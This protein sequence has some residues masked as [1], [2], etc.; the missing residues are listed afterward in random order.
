MILD[1][2]A[3]QRFRT[4][5]REHFGAVADDPLYEAVSAGRKLQGCEHWLPLFHERLETLF[6]Y[7]AAARR[8]LSS[9]SIKTNSLAPGLTMLC[10]TPTGRVY[11]WPNASSV[12]TSPS[13]VSATS[14]PAVRH[15]TT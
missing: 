9:T 5:Y 13:F 2:A 6:D 15:T 10:S 7:L 14:L 8:Y 12:V 3:I 11:A 1:E 4:R